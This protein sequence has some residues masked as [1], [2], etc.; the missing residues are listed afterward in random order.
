MS[1]LNGSLS[2]YRTVTYYGTGPTVYVPYINLPT[3]VNIAVYPSKLE[4]AKTW[5]KKTFR[6]DFS[7][8]KSSNGSFVF[9]ALTWS[10]GIHRV[11][12]PIALNVV[13]S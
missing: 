6:V 2:V 7:P 1:S 11:R 8:I 4:F 3:G 10:N 12:S 5:E 9:G 13:I